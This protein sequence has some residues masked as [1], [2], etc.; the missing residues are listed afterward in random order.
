MHR[1]HI[2]DQVIIAECLRRVRND[3]QDD[4]ESWD[5]EEFLK[6]EEEMW[7]TMYPGLASAL[8]AQDEVG[9]EV[10][11]GSANEGDN[12]CQFFDGQDNAE[13]MNLQKPRVP[14]PDTV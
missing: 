6:L 5:D 13:V 9:D 4:H 1:F 12:L 10:T 14:Y 2:R 7:S 11:L 8:T 3:D